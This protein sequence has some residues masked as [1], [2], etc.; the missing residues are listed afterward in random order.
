MHRWYPN[1]L[2]QYAGKTYVGNRYAP[3]IYELS[4]NYTL[5]DGNTILRIG[6][7]AFLR[8]PNKYLRVWS[9][10]IEVDAGNGIT[11]EDP[12]RLGEEP[13]LMMQYSWDYMR[14]FSSELKEG[15][16]RL[17][18]YTKTVIFSGGLGTGRVFGVEF[19]LSDSCNTSILNGWIDVEVGTQR[20]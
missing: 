10:G 11:N 14:T 17:G 12:N 6:R 5:E 19:R 1:S 2:I 3:K 16:G 7:T 20:T 4:Q 8:S 9:V 18:D 13:E 15:I